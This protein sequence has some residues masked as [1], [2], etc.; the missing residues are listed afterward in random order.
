IVSPTAVQ[1]E[2]VTQPAPDDHFAAS[3]HRSVQGSGLGRVGRAG[4]CP[5]IADW[6]VPAASVEEGGHDAILSAPNDHFTACP[7]GSVT[8]SAIRCVGCVSGRPTIRDGIV[9][10]AG[11]KKV[12]GIVNP[13][14]D[15][16]FGTAPH[17]RVIHS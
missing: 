8:G 14:P 17:C 4:S 12:Y 7:H 1:I 15:D 6:I 13:A 16:H 2:A 11:V 9:P 5:A 3:P 10:A